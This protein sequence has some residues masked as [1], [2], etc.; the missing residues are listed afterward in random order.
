MRGG[1]GPTRLTTVVLLDIVGSTV[2]AGEL[3]DERWRVALSRFRRLVRTDLK[4]HQGHEEDTAGDGFF[5]TF[6]QPAAAVRCAAAIVSDVQTIGLDVRCG[7]H[8]G[9]MGSVE[10]RPGGVAVHAAARVMALAGAAEICC[11]STVRDLVMGQDIS[12]ASRGLRELKGVPGTWETLIVTATPDHLP[13]PLTPEEARTRLQRLQ[14]ERQRRTRRAVLAAFAILGFSVIVWTSFVLLQ[15]TGTT[16]ERIPVDRV[17]RLDPADGRIT[18]SLDVGAQPTG[19]AI[20]N[21]TVWVLRLEVGEAVRVDPVSGVAVSVPTGGKPSDIAID[22]GGTVWVLNAFPSA[23]LVGIDPDRVRIDEAA[24]PLETGARSISAGEG[25]VWV[26]NSL[27]GSVSRFDTTTRKAKVMY[28][29]DPGS[30][31][32]GVAVGGGAV[33]VATGSS[34][35]KLDPSDGHVIGSAPL[36]YQAYEIAYGAGSVWV[37]HLDDDAVSRIDPEHLSAVSMGVGDGPVDIAVDDSAAWVT[38]G[39]SGSVSRIDAQTNAVKSIVV[40]SS[41][42]GVAAGADDVWVAVHAR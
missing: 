27:Q 37:T 31:V 29:S 19:V 7:L 9:E 25:A 41:P 39:L 10:G 40:G 3:G 38:N 23:S 16:L 34:V 21:R 17:G 11:T 18:D 30:R 1:T 4:R 8:T 5:A 6:G 26:T 2:V 13:P 14:P 33:W 22:A 42:D 24:I 20:G 15:R 28:R 12:F 36:L 32:R 35:L